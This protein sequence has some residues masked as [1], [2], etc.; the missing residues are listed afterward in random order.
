MDGLVENDSNAQPFNPMDIN[1]LKVQT[2][3]IP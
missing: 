1:K 2:K 3:R